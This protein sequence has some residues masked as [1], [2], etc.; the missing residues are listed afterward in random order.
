MKSLFKNLCLL[1]FTHIP[2]N[3]RKHELHAI[4]S[5]NNSPVE[6]YLLKILDRRIW[7]KQTIDVYNEVLNQTE[8]GNPKHFSYF[9]AR[10]IVVLRLLFLFPFYT[11]FL[12]YSSIEWLLEGCFDPHHGQ[13]RVLPDENAPR[14][15]YVL[16]SV[17]PSR[18]IFEDCFSSK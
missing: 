15:T 16:T 14:P 13:G 10:T 9:S 7:K 2:E 6:L 18:T 4:K 12:F 3:E 1:G 8:S 11:M 5:F 17:W